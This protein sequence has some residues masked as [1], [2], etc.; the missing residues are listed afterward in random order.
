[1]KKVLNK[2]ITLQVEQGQEL[3]TVETTYFELIFGCCKRPEEG[4]YSWD[5]IEKISRIK[6]LADK[7]K[8][9]SYKDTEIDVEDA[10]FDFI[11][12]RVMSNKSWVTFDSGLLEFKKYLETL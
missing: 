12:Q 2:T 4:G 3:L 5:M 6:T 1:M 10:D 7:A 11:K 8:D 9:L